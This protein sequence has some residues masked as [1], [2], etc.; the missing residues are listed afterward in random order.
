MKGLTID[1]LTPDE[2]RIIGFYNDSI[3]YDF[4]SSLPEQQPEFRPAHFQPSNFQYTQSTS[5][6]PPNPNCNTSNQVPTKITPEVE[7][8]EIICELEPDQFYT[9]VVDSDLDSDIDDTS[10]LQSIPITSVKTNP[11]QNMS[12]DVKTS[13]AQII[14]T[15]DN[16]QLQRVIELQARQ[17]EQFHKQNEQLS[18]QIDNLTAMII[19]LSNHIT[20]TETLYSTDT[21]LNRDAKW[22]TD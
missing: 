15:A 9:E 11:V 4:S 13:H 19:R 16:D 5:A 20:A 18:Q 6:V 1:Q 22:T 3:N 17:I 7:D 8:A 2:K 21:R 12:N 10:T 14:P